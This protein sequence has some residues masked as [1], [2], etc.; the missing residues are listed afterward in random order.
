MYGWHGR[1][2]FVDL[3][4]PSFKTELIPEEH[5]QTG[6]GGRALAIRLFQDYAHLDPFD[7][8]IPLIMTTGPLSG[9]GTP[10]AERLCLLSRSP[11]TGTVFDTSSGGSFAHALKASGYDGLFITGKSPR[12]QALR[13]TP[14]GA[15]FISAE[16][17]W[18]K[19]TAATIA[20]FNERGVATIGPA[21]EQG[22]LYANV[23]FSDG[24]ND[25]RG[26]LGAVMGRKNLKAIVANGDQQTKVAEPDK[27]SN[28]HQDIMRLF[29][30]S[31]VLMGQYGIHEFGTPAFID[32]TNQRGMLPTNNFKNTFFDQANTLSGPS[33]RR[34]Y[35]PA[36]DSCH[37]CPIAC[38]K[39]N[40]QNARLPEFSAL[41]HLGPLIDNSDLQAAVNANRLCREL[42]LDP[43]SAAATLATRAEIT[44]DY[45]KPYELTNILNRIC[46]PS[47]EEPF[48]SLGSR[49]LADELGKPEASMTVKSLELPA[50]DP[51]GAIGIALSYCTS[52]LGGSHEHANLHTCEILRKPVAVDRFSF[53]GKARL[54]KLAEDAHAV[55]DSLIVCHNA[56]YAASLEEYCDALSAITGFDYSP[57]DL[58]RTGEETV[59]TEHAINKKNGFSSA[60]DMLPERF[61][62]EPG[63]TTNGQSVPA[64]NKEA[65]INELKR[66]DRI[67][68][69]SG[70]NLD[71]HL[72]RE[73]PK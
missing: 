52:T 14:S 31:P 1:F 68:K 69:S 40:H 41:N 63:T 58:L 64:I 38:K 62:T 28:A 22:I 17:L 10:A 24:D 20:H 36:H 66:Y 48:V 44:G 7:P 60:D 43:L 18:G 30:A 51:R 53:T 42:G 33:L 25:S 26:G 29:R 5:L 37:D 9:T 13:I 46:D 54:L 6:V 12:P 61:F 73:R 39:L 70:Q 35:A 4:T 72:T 11:L 27:L 47:G 8:E 71:E 49:R 23:V 21:G 15:E 56:F 2:L 67:R 57:S 16:T 65:F 55:Y 59:M 34:E 45:P 3:S 50:F 19:T 32:L